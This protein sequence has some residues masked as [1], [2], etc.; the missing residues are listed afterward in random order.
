MKVKLVRALLLLLAAYILVTIL[1]ST[2]T[3]TYAMIYKTPLFING[4]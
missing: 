3:E 4:P 1:A 2:T